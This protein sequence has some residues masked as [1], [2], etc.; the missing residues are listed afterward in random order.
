MLEDIAL[1]VRDFGSAPTLAEMTRLTLAD[2]KSPGLPARM[3]LRRFI[4]L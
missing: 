4:P 2:K 3:L 1:L